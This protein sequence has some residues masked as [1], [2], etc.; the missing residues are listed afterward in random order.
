MACL[1]KRPFY[2]KLTANKEMCASSKNRR[3][4]LTRRN[5]LA[6]LSASSSGELSPE[7]RPGNPWSRCEPLMP[8]LTPSKSGAS[9][10]LRFFNIAGNRFRL[11]TAIHYNRGLIFILRFLTH[12]QYDRGSWKQ[13]L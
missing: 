13:E 2:A 1:P 12:A 5:M 6:R 3:W 10:W 7:K 8:T 4:Q 11:V 9:A